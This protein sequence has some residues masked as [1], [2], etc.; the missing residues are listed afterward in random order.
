MLYFCYLTS[1]SDASGLVLHKIKCSCYTS[2]IDVFVVMTHPLTLCCSCSNIM[3]RSIRI[4][5][6]KSINKKDFC[7]RCG[8]LICYNFLSSSL[9]NVYTHWCVELTEFFDNI[10]K[11]PIF[12]PKFNF[13][14]I[15]KANMVKHPEQ[16]V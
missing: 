5:S 8:Q 14:E 7:L 9:V 10:F 4:H 16:R 3:Q 11:M 6:I 13:F 1:P 15:L 2:K 12:Q